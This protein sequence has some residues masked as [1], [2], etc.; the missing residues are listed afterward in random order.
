[1]VDDVRPTVTLDNVSADPL[2]QPGM[3]MYEKLRIIN[4]RRNEAALKAIG[5]DTNELT[6][7]A[8]GDKAPLKNGS[9]EKRKSRRIPKVPTR[10]STRLRNIPAVNYKDID[11]NNDQGV[12]ESR[13]ER[14]KRPAKAELPVEFPDQPPGK[15]RRKSTDRY[16][17]TMVPSAGNKNAAMGGRLSIKYLDVDLDYLDKTFLGKIIPPLGGQV[18]R[19]VMET[20][21]RKAT[22][23]FSRMSGIQKWKNCIQL[24][25]NVYGNG[26]KNVFLNG[27]RQI[28]VSPV[29]SSSIPNCNFSANNIFR[30]TPH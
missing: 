19:A 4:I 2:Y 11:E 20:S 27:G 5:L 16:N 30:G 28:T 6:T 7:L 10:F 8:R 3:S 13:P 14:R 24:F 22:P 12:A 29:S 21:C 9:R 1:M 17:P 26:Y 15:R 23:K 18:K 25:V